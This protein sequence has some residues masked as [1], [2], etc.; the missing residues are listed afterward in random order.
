[1]LITRHHKHIELAAA[2]P[3]TLFVFEYRAE[4]VRGISMG[5]VSGS[6]LIPVILL[7]KPGEGGPVY[8]E[9]ENKMVLDYGCDGV[10]DYGDEPP[11]VTDNFTSPIPHGMLRIGGDMA[12]LR[13][14]RLKL[15]AQMA[16]ADIDLATM[17]TAPGTILPDGSFEVWSWW[18]W[19]NEE[20][21]NR[22]GGRRFFEFSAQ[23]PNA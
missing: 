7:D 17:K 3:N 18:I 6:E 1:M 10:V 8:A 15:P 22:E 2:P 21:K 5:P 20:E 9:V 11:A 12:L 23:R 19:R 13:I 14:K 16:M 4:I